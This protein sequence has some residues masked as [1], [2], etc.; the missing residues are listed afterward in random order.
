VITFESNGG[1][2]IEDVSELPNL[3]GEKRIYLDLETTSGDPTQDSL[4]V[5][6]QCGIAGVCI[7][8]ASGAYYIPID[9]EDGRK[10]LPR[11]NII[12]W[13]RDILVQCDDWVNHNI[14]YDMHVLANDFHIIPACRCV[15]TMTRAKIIN[16]D[17]MTYNMT[18]LAQAFLGEDIGEY[19]HNLK[20]YLHKN[21]DY[22][23]IPRDIIGPYGCHDVF[24]T[25]RLDRYIQHMMPEQCKEVEATEIQLTS[26]L[27]D[28]ER[29]GMRVDMVELM[30]LEYGLTARL[31]Q[32]EEILQQKLGYAMRPHT[33]EDCH[34][35]LCNRYGLPVLGTTDTGAPSFDKHVLAMYLSHP[36]APKDI[37]ELLLEYRHKNTLNNLFVKRYQEHQV[38][39]VMHPSYNQAVRTGRMSCSDPNAQQLSPEAKALIHPKPGHGFLSIDYSQIEFRLIGHYIKDPAVIVAYEEDPDTD[40]HTWV[41][42]MCGIH[43]KPAKNVNFCMGFGGGRK[44][45]LEML[46]TNMELVGSLGIQVDKLIAEGKCKEADRQD[47]FAILCKRRA[48]QVYDKYHNTLP[49]LKRTSYNAAKVCESR[50]Y[51]FNAYGRHRKLPGKAAWRAFNAIVQS[52][53]AD[54]M[55]ERTVAT[56][57]RFNERLGRLGITQ[58]A[59]VH[60]ET[61]FHVP[62]DLLNDASLIQSIAKEMEDSRIKFRVPM[63]VAVGQSNKTWVEAAKSAKPIRYI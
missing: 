40:F 22:G 45:V 15:D 62:L 37:V 14:K 5:W 28:M 1:I 4:N 33:N 54:V 60:D 12:T 49:G 57:S 39:G 34:E 53:A 27:F 35:V 63:R 19:E 31:L 52:T 11:E 6:G 17:R 10:N 3:A 47:V 18:D 44:R 29:E 41:A 38:N 51:I 23:R 59:S 16:S 21:K 42:E 7:G 30:K 50:G 46:E 8:G 25:R 61:L 56:S 13:L 20:P 43:R 55:K 36:F 26:V 48:E 2:L 24:T 9:H 32:I 58:V